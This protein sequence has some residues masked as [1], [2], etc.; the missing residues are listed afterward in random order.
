[1]YAK[2]TS[3]FS[4]NRVCEVE[5]SL[6]ALKNYRSVILLLK[7]MTRDRLDSVAE[8]IVRSV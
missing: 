7:E 1:M 8:K 6:A 5:M 2:S 4:N 3:I